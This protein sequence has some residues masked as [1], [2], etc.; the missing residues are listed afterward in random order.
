MP[1]VKIFNLDSYKVIYKS[2]KH[3]FSMAQDCSLLIR[4]TR[5]PTVCILCKTRLEDKIYKRLEDWVRGARIKR[6][7]LSPNDVLP[8]TTVAAVAVGSENS[9]SGDTYFHT[10]RSF[11]KAVAKT[12]P[13]SLYPLS[14]SKELCHRANSRSS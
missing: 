12:H 11:Y 5:L 10:R 6:E 4:F 8:L 7:T 9:N 13:N 2:R 14:K 1:V 3:K